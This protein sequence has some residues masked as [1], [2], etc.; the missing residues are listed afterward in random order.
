MS[1]LTRIGRHSP[2]LSAGLLTGVLVLAV[3]QT[4]GASPFADAT[5]ES[6]G[7]L[8]QLLLDMVAAQRALMT[9]LSELMRDSQGTGWSAIAFVFIGASFLYGILHAAGPGHGKIV[10]GA[11]AATQRAGYG[12]SLALAGAASLLQAVSA[13][14]IIF[15]ALTI[16]GAALSQASAAARSAELVSFAAVTLLGAWLTQRAVVALWRRRAATSDACCGP[17]VETAP[18]AA[19][20]WGPVVGAVLSV[21]LRPCSGAILVLLLGTSYG[22]PGLAVVSVLAMSAGTALTVGT[23][24][25]VVTTVR[26]MAGRLTGSALPAYAATLG[27]V[28]AGLG[29]LVILTFGIGLLATAL[30]PAHP[31]MPR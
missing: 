20:G 25:T 21:G 17:A 22:M 11:Y 16:V 19:R 6:P 12:Q 15:V 4:V 5:A 13:I 8:A 23:V 26:L 29:G 1:A 2:L 28:G 10:I 14:A 7:W 24:A 18:P 27:Q 9:H 3:P 30:G 31:L